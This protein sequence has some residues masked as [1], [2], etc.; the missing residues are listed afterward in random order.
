MNAKT[1]RL[2]V[3]MALALLASNFEAYVPIH[4]VEAATASQVTVTA[5]VLN[6]RSGPG[7]NYAI[8]SQVKR[9]TRL[10]VQKK[11]GGWLQVRLPNGRIGW[12]SE[13]YVRPVSASPAPAQGGSGQPAAPSAQ[14]VEVTASVLN[15][16]SGPGTNYAIISQ[17]KRNTRLTVQKKQGGWLQVRLPNGRTGWV[18]AQYVRPV[19]PTAPSQGSAKQPPAG[20]TSATAKTATVTASSLNVR[21]GPG[22][23]YAVIRSIPKG[24]RVTVLEQL[25]SW[26]RVQAGNLIGWVASAY[27]RVET[28]TSILPAP[29]PPPAP[30]TPKPQPISAPGTE[31]PPASNDPQAILRGKRI[32][33]DP[34]HG[35]QDPGAIGRTLGTLEKTVNLQVAHLVKARLEDLGAEVFM[36][37]EDDRYPTLAERVAFARKVQG[38]VFISIHHNSALDQTLRGTM[39][40]YAK[41]GPSRL[42]A[43]AVHEELVRAIGLRDLQ[44]RRANYYV[45][46]NN[47]Y[48]A[49]LLEIGFLS[50]P[51]EER[52]VRDPE[53]QAR[54]AQGI[55]QGLIRYFALSPNSQPDLARVAY[56]STP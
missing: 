5:S 24:T 28:S 18:S 4:T 55:V 49:I 7:T 12:V 51:D 25:G 13:Q 23:Q 54:A 10:T 27:L 34:G 31:P 37:R 39:T 6:V 22:T 16:R 41:D 21:S 44:V 26:W 29:S 38:D 14:T 1:L 17:V 35:G 56:S 30:A 42:L 9:N 48:P 53:F 46:V 52:L 32:I 40:F 3:A 20:G 11:Q 47:P 45:I 2:A 15:V 33:L 36:T 8:I 43:E 19:H 50:H